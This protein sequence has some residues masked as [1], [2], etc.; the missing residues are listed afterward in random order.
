ME[1]LD[2]KQGDFVQISN[3]RLPS[4]KLIKIQPQS[5][6]FLEITD[7]RAVLEFT[8]RQFT[9]LSPNDCFWINYADHIFKVKVLETE[10]DPTG[11]LV[12]ETD[13]NVDFAP[14]VGYVEPDYKRTA[15]G[16]VNANQKSIANSIGQYGFSPKSPSGPFNGIGQSLRSS[17]SG[18]KSPAPTPT[19]ASTTTTTHDTSRPTALKLPKNTMFFGV[20]KPSKKEEENESKPAAA[21][22]F[23]GKGRSLR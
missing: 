23:Q 10:P 4:G 9:T 17:S 8:L 6:D 5:P 16:A 1:T 12:I 14:P 18:T 11:I 20:S 13:L 21:P 15:S 3:T 19:S 7:P 22:A 2:L